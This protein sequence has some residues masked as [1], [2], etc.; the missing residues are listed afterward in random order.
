[1]SVRYRMT[2]D[3]VTGMVYRGQCPYN[4]LH[5]SRRRRILGSLPQN[6]SESNECLCGRFHCEGTLGDHST[7]A[8]GSLDLQCSMCSQHSGWAWYI[9]YRICS[10]DNTLSDYHCIPCQYYNSLTK[11]I[12]LYGQILASTSTSCAILQ[13]LVS[14][15][16]M[17]AVNT[18]NLKF[19][20][21]LIPN[22]CLYE[23]FSTFNRMVFLYVS[24]FN[25][26]VLIELAHTCIEL[27]GRNCKL[28]VWFWK[29]FHKFKVKFNKFWDLQWS[30]LHAF[31]TFLLLLYNKVADIF[32]F[33][34]GSLPIVQCIRGTSGV[35]SVVS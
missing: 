7:K 16:N 21:S 3:N 26:F 27:H 14:C 2:F 31:A 22:S 19:F 34:S 20:N 12:V 29:P 1:M 23:G 8:M 6:V 28:I 30:V 32:I 9:F 33:S 4:Q 24:A 35:K 10:T 13:I 18:W 11:C 5:H 15:N 17:A 25:P